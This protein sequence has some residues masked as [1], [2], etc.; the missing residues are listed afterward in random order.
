MLVNKYCTNLVF[1]LQIFRTNAKN[2]CA[3][4]EGNEPA[5]RSYSDSQ[6]YCYIRFPSMPFQLTLG[7]Y[8]ILGST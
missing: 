7:I 8:S 4:Q 5:V 3:T 2:I 1:T 6:C